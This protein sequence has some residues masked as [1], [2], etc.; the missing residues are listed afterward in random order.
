M[1]NLLDSDIF[2]LTLAL[3]TYLAVLALY[4]KT[5]I[6]LLN[7][8]LVS[9][10]AIITLLKIMGIE[11]EVFRKGTQVIHFMLGPSVVALGYVLFEQVKYL[12]GNVLSILT[13]IT[14]GAFV[15]IVSVMGIGY[16]MGADEVLI[17]MMQPK[18]VTTP[19]AMSIAERSGGIPSLTAVIVVGVGIFGSITG[20]VLLKVMGIESKIAK[21]LALGASSH[22]VGTAAAIQLG[23]V[24]GAISG[25]AIGLMGIA[26]AILVPLVTFVL[27][28]F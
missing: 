22:G 18:S 10:F 3:G 24:E 17:A 28:F 14:V 23:V 13:S 8:L 7:P 12:H 27:T 2:S 5:K 25:L 11:Y 4:K 21:G 20:P 9:I 6:L 1:N 26:T 16:L 15:G 19:I